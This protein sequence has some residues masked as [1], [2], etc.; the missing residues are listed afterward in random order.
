M[1]SKNPFAA[2]QMDS[3]SDQEEVKY[4]VKVMR[5]QTP[6]ASP[7][8]RV[9]KLEEGEEKPKNVFKSPFSQKKRKQKLEQDKEGWVSIQNNQPGFIDDNSSTESEKEIRKEIVMEALVLEPTSPPE[10]NEESSGF[11]SMLSRGT[12]TTLSAMDWAEKVRMSLEQ[13]EQARNKPP[14]AAQKT[15]DFVNGLGRLSFFRRPLVTEE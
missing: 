5:I 7:S 8:F 15:E 3:D 1:S 6:V 4:E 11:Y 9:W 12:G 13:A 2:L 10:F 14:T